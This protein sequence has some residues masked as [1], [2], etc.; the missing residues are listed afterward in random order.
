[1][2]PPDP[3]ITRID[4][5]W[6]HLDIH[7]NGIRFHVVEALPADDR[8][9]DGPATARPLVMLLHGFGSFWWTWRHQLRGLSGVRVVAVDLRG[10]GGSDKPPRGYDGWTLAGDTA[11]LIR[12]LGHSSATLVGHADGGLVCWATALLHP[13]L[14]R[15]IAVVSSPHPAALRHSA[16]TRAD[17][18]RALLPWLLRYQVPIWPE[19][20]LT[21]RDGVELERLIRSRAGQGWQA[22]ADFAETL[23]HLRTGIRIP[24]A[25]HC[26][27]EYQRWAVRSQLRAEGRRFMKAL[28]LRTLNIPLLHLRGADDPY[29]LADPV[30]KTRRYAPHGQYV[31]LSGAGHFAHEEAPDEVNAHLMRFL[32][33]LG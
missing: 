5:P 30:E 19:R 21:R 9:A 2:P 25:A 18:G 1:M 14:V 13:R 26:A 20:S 29:V 24:S 15:A 11:G 4:G 32:A 23:G 17:Q 8:A 28:D 22:T 16:L 31:S 7:A 12:A 27:L 33:R 10:Y 6:R 3:S